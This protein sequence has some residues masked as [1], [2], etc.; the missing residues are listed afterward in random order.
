M[1]VLEGTSDAIIDSDMRVQLRGPDVLDAA[2]EQTARGALER[3]AQLEQARLTLQNRGDFGNRELG[4][5][6]T[7]AQSLAAVQAEI[8]RLTA[9]HAE[10]TARAALTFHEE[11]TGAAPTARAKRSNGE[12]CVPAVNDRLSAWQMIV[13][14]WFTCISVL[15]RVRM[16]PTSPAASPEASPK[17]WPRPLR[18]VIPRS[19]SANEPARVVSIARWI[20]A[21]VSPRMSCRYITPVRASGF[22]TT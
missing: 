1:L 21:T 17:W 19:A 16:P 10:L 8:A 6:G 13:S 18:T 5:E 11:T 14:W 12:D 2:G 22:R 9:L 3:I 4:L 15:S 20:S 7:A